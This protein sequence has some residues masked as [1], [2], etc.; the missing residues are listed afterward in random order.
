MLTFFSKHW[1]C[2]FTE[3][4]TQRSSCML[5]VTMQWKAGCV[6]LWQKECWWSVTPSMIKFITLKLS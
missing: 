1:S 3:T 2:E 5:N 6:G 4:V